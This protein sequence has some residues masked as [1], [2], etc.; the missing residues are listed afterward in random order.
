MYSS[1][2]RYGILTSLFYDCNSY[3]CKCFYENNFNN[4]SNKFYEVC[5]ISYSV[6]LKNACESFKIHYLCTSET[7]EQYDTVI[8]IICYSF[9]Q[10]LWILAFI[11]VVKLCCSVHTYTLIFKLLSNLYRY[12]RYKSCFVDNL[13]FNTFN[14]YYKRRLLSLEYNVN[15]K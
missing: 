13:F 6:S 12:Y 7:E 3:K 1:E 8:S 15:K 14:S 9:Y 4:L 2:I 5:N 10:Y 11:S